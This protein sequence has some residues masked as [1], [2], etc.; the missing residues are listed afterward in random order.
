[1]EEGKYDWLIVGAGLFGSVFAHEMTKAGKRCLVIDR[2]AE[3]GGN[4]ACKMVDGIYVHEYGAHIIHTD[5]RE[6]WDYINALMPLRPYHHEVMA[7]SNGNIYTLPFC[8]HTF[9]ELYGVRTPNEALDAIMED[10]VSRAEIKSVQDLALATVGRLIY[11]TLIKGY[12]EKQWGCSCDELP[13]FILGRI[14]LRFSYETSYYD[15]ENV[16]IPVDGNYNT[17]FRN[18]LAGSDVRLDTPFDSSMLTLASRTLYTGSIDSF[19]GYRYGRLGYRS[20]R[21]EWC[22]DK[23]SQGCAVMNYTGRE[24]QF[25]RIIEHNFFNVNGHRGPVLHSIE[26]PVPYDGNNEPIYPINTDK[27]NNLYHKYAELAGKDGK[28]I[29][30]GRLG[31]YRYYAMDSCIEAAIA[32]ARQ[33]I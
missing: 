17:L 24:V 20:L 10:R 33:Q 32:L 30:G 18:L 11:Q 6:I 2:R 16:G 4:C 13:A 25:T 27:N 7:C 14:P 28:V 5:K 29:F 31:A 15:V 21:F 12:T 22:K 3:V 26:Y 19:F 9:R 23:V 8:M 1:M